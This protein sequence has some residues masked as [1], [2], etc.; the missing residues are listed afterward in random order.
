MCLIGRVDTD[1]L[2]ENSVREEV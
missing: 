1:T 2:Y